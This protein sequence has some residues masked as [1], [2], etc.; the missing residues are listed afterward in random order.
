MYE[1]SRNRFKE[2]KHFCLQYPELKE[3]KAK[4][5][6]E[7]ASEGHD[8]TGRIASELADIEKAMNLIETT[9]FN[10]GNFPGEKILKIVTEGVVL[11]EVCPE[12]HDICEWY[13]RKFYW[14]L[15]KAKGVI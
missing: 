15:D 2:L 13:L 14:M 5:Y 1:L 8:P 9:A 7:K 6:S 12:D 3:R 10:I 4:L 11:G